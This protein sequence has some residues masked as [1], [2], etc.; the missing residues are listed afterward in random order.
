MFT[1]N[2]SILISSLFEGKKYTECLDYVYKELNCTCL[3]DFLIKVKQSKFTSVDASIK[4]SDKNK[5]ILIFEENFLT[6][7]P[8]KINYN[9]QIYDYTVTFTAPKIIDGYLN[10]VYCIDSIV[11]EGEELKLRT[12]EDYN[13]IPFK[14]I[15]NCKKDFTEI[16]ERIQESFLYYINDEYKSRFLCNI[17]SI[18][19]VLSYT[20]IDSYENSLK[21]QLFLMEKFNFSYTDFDNMSLDRGK[22]F[23]NL[24]IKILN[25]RNSQQTQTIE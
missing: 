14:I 20:L 4:L 5:E 13:L 15:N 23:I 16:Y 8:D 19:T 9:K 21:E 1:Y 7:L 11:Y 3:I 2:D 10:S 12:L 22:K 17:D 18:L 6:N 24:G 25:E